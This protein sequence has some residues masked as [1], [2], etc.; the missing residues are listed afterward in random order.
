MKYIYIFLIS[1]TGI[2]SI[3]QMRSY[4]PDSVYVY[5]VQNGDSSQK[6]LT[7]VE[8]YFKSR[9]DARSDSV[10]AFTVEQTGKFIPSMRS[11]ISFDAKGNPINWSGHTYDASSNKW[12]P[13]Y[14]AEAK[15]NANGDQ[16]EYIN[17]RYDP[18][19]KDFIN[20]S[21]RRSVYRGKVQDSSINCDWDT[22]KKVWIEKYRNYFEHSGTY[23]VRTI[24]DMKRDGQWEFSTELI[25]TRDTVQR[26]SNVTSW[27]DDGIKRPANEDVYIYND[28]G[29]VA[30]KIQ[31]VYMPNT[32][33]WVPYTKTEY[34]YD[35]H[36]YRIM[37]IQFRYNT[38]GEN[39]RIETIRRYF[40]RGT[41]PILDNK[42]PIY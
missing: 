17:K 24:R 15:Y 26:V 30:V 6:M 2:S 16:T 12:S 20:V 19:K 34:V 3:A 36:R 10:H 31:S 8:R 37:E 39:P 22:I 9:T 18:H 41:E 42:G 32:L 21:L 14:R 40:F 5:Q 7:R 33:Q 13:S 25:I 38:D 4:F 29:D 27:V 35:E 11:F 1:L 23:H 28:S